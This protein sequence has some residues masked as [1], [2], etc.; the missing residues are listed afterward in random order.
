MEVAGR[1]NFGEV[2]FATGWDERSA[3]LFVLSSGEWQRYRLPKSSHTY[4]HMWQTEWTR[5]RE[6]E[7]E[8]YLMDCH[9]T[10]FELSP[11]AYDDSIW[12]VNP[13]STH[14]RVIPD[15][16]SFR[17]Q[18]VMAGNQTTPISDNNVVVGQ[19]QSGL[20]VGKTDDIWEFGK[21]K[22]WGG[23]WRDDEVLAGDPSDP[24]LMTGYDEKVLHLSQE[25]DQPVEFR[26]EV[27]FL[28]NGRWN[29]YETI[30]VDANG[31]EHHEFP[32]GFSA[33]WVR[34]VSDTD[35]EAT[36]YFTYS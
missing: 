26:V 17:G 15:F 32:S 13:I 8:R 16:C 20:W 19:P 9:G 14:L 12:G 33:H 25:S 23:P 1:G 30:S 36:A 31:Y 6:V 27:D 11:L 4:D 24:Y 3:I 35:C 29:C 10:F 21:P 22:G 28:G 7:T 5:I 2:I 18:L 34:L